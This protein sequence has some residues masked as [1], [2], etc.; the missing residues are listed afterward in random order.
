MAFINEMTDQIDQRC[1]HS[2]DKKHAR[3]LTCT[4][5][6]PLLRLWWIRSPR[7]W[8]LLVWVMAHTPENA[9]LLPSN[10]SSRQSHGRRT[11]E[12]RSVFFPRRN[13]SKTPYVKAHEYTEAPHDNIYCTVYITHLAPL[14][15]R[16]EVYLSTL[17]IE[18]EI[19]D[20]T[21]RL[22]AGL[23]RLDFQVMLMSIAAG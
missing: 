5:L 9:L 10:R 14:R 11:N 22:A 2:L 21:E 1:F 12:G 17:E 15:S 3:P 8:S 19:S 7:C 23:D 20:T 4:H 18:S 6:F 16:F 13:G